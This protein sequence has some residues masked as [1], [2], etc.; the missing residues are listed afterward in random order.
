MKAAR[1]GAVVLALAALALFALPSAEEPSCVP[2]PVGTDCVADYECLEMEFC[3]DLNTCQSYTACETDDECVEV[4]DGC[5]P[6]SMGGRSVA[7]NGQWTENWYAG[8][9]CQP[10]TACL[11]VYLCNDF[12]PACVQGDCAMVPPPQVVCGSDAEVFP[13]FPRECL[14]NDDCALVLHQTN[15]CGTEVAWGI[16]RAALEDFR[17]AEDEC[18]GEMYHCGCATFATEA[19]DG[20]TGWGADAFSV[21]CQEN[22]CFSFVR[23]PAAP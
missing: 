1:I 14:S 7:I 8:W 22:R 20:N 19:D 12:V 6:C 13:E 2:V 4:S 16:R 21:R 3:T 11:A 10:D 15:C 9:A 23:D 18:R 5:C 17:A